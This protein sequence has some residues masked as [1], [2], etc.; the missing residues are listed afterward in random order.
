MPG[1]NAFQ[2]AEHGIAELLVKSTGLKAECAQERTH[3]SPLDGIR[4]CRLHERSAVTGRAGRLGHPQIRDMQPATPYL[5]EQS[6]EDL[7]ALAPQE[8]VDR[9]VGRQPGG[10][11]VVV[12]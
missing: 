6:A 9:V 1:R 7:A 2:R 11:D 4:L 3:A 12:V 8:E 10:C 5:P